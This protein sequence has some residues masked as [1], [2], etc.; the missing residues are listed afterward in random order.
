MKPV[1]IALFALLAAFALGVMAAGASGV[2]LAG[3]LGLGTGMD[4]KAAA[5]AMLGQDAR[6]MENKLADALSRL[7]S[8]KEAQ[9]SK[10]GKSSQRAS[11]A[12]LALKSS[13]AETE[14]A[15]NNSTIGNSSAYTLEG[16]SAGLAALNNSSTMATGGS[17]QPQGMGSGYKTSFNGYYSILASR[18]ETGKSDIKSSMSLRGSFDVDKSVQFSDRGF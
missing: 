9:L 15:T 3:S 1:M 4:S 17:S 13:P 12:S 10:S 18:H 8:W 11:S 5:S 16:G 2:T 7:N 6:M 14:M